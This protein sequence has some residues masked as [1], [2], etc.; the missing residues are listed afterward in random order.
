[1]NLFTP[2]WPQNLICMSDSH[3]RSL[4]QFS[5]FSSGKLRKEVCEAVFIDGTKRMCSSREFMSVLKK[6]QTY[7]KGLFS[8]SWCFK[9]GSISSVD[10]RAENMLE[11]R[12]NHA[13]NTYKSSVPVPDQ[14]G[15]TGRKFQDLKAM[16][17][18]TVFISLFLSRIRCWSLFAHFQL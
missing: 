8:N 4:W 6:K 15:P 13:R 12:T 10:M 7:A 3:A 14:Y 16:V 2:Q 17:C 1:M 11:S 18:V 5:P 9:S